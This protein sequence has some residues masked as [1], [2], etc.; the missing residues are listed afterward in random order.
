MLT[1][2]YDTMTE[3]LNDLY[4]Q[5]F[6]YDF[7]LVTKKTYDAS[8][9]LPIVDFVIVLIIRFENDSD[10]TESAILYAI[11]SS[12][13]CIKGTLVNGFGIYADP[14]TNLFINS[15]HSQK[16]CG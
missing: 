11:V 12:K 14:L 16:E 8:Y 15:I 2:P 10:P 1:K 6:T 9:N 7:N 5:G 3:A 13:H 4:N